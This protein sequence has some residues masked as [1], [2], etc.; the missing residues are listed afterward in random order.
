MDLINNSIEQ[1]SKGLY[2]DVDP[3]NQPPDTYRYA[4]NAVNESNEGDMSTISNE[5]SNNKYAFLKDNYVLIGSVYIGD[6]ETCIFSV[7]KDNNASEIG[8][9]SE[10]SSFKNE[11]TENNYKVWCNDSNSLSSEKLNFKVEKQ[12]QATFRLRRGCEKMVY[13]VDDY[14]V[15]RQVNLSN[16]ELYKNSTG[17]FDAQKFSIIKG[18]K[19]IPKCD[20]VEIIESQGNLQPGTVSVLLQYSDEEKNFTNFVL[21][22]PNII[23]YKDNHK[24]SF[25]AIDGSIN[26]EYNKEFSEGR[27]DKAI[28]LSFSNFDV[29][30][31]FYRLAF[32]HYGNNTLE[33]SEVYLSDI[34]ST[35]Q[36]TYTYSYSATLEKTDYNYIETFNRNNFIRSAKTIEQKDNRLVLGNIKGYDLDFS[37][38]Q[39]LASKINVDCIVKKSTINSVNDIHNTK[40]PLSKINGTGFI[41]GEVTSLGIVYVFEDGF[42]SPVMHIPGKNNKDSNDFVYNTDVPNDVVG[43][44]P[45]KHSSNDPK[46]F[47]NNTGNYKYY[48]RESCENFD[49]WGVDS[50]GDS[51][52]NTYVRHHRFPSRSD[53]NLP[54]FVEQQNESSVKQI[55]YTLSFGKLSDKIKE[56]SKECREPNKTNLYCNNPILISFN[57][58]KGNNEKEKIEAEF[59]TDI[60]AS[61]YDTKNWFDSDGTIGNVSDFTLKILVGVYEKKKDGTFEVKRNLDNLTETNGKLEITPNHEEKES[62]PDSDGNITVSVYYKSNYVVSNSIRNEFSFRELFDILLTKNTE[63]DSPLKPIET[64]ILGVSLSNI[65]LP[66]KELTGKNCIG[67]YVVKQERKLTDRTILDTGVVVP[68]WEAGDFKTA[69]FV[70]PVFSPEGYRVLSNYPNDTPSGIY[71]R[72]FSLIAPRHKFNDHT[73]DN[74]THIVEQGFYTTNNSMTHITGQAVQNVNDYKSDNVS[75]SYS[76]FE[77]HDGMTLKN[78]I[79]YQ[80]MKYVNKIRIHSFYLENKGKIDIF[81]LNTCEYGTVEGEPDMLY[82]MDFSNKKLIFKADRD[83][84]GLPEYNPAND[85]R[86]YPY[87]YIYNNHNSF[88]SDFQGAKYYK[89]NNNISTESTYNS[90][91]GDFQIGGLR[92]YSTLYLN[93]V[94]RIQRQKRSWWQAIAGVALAVIGLVAAIFSGGSSLVLVGSGLALLGATA[95]GIATIIK[96]DNFNKAMTEHWERGLKR[97]VM[98]YW[99][100]HVYIRDYAQPDGFEIIKYQD[101][102]IRW[103]T[104]I[105][106]DLVFETDIN[107]SLRI[108]PKSDRNNFLKPFTSHMKNIPSKVEYGKGWGATICLVDNTSSGGWWYWEDNGM[109]LKSETLEELFFLNKLCKQDGGRKSEKAYADNGWSYRG[110]PIPPIYFVN[111]DYQNQRKVLSHYMTPVEYSFCSECKETFPQRFVWSE[112]SQSETLTDNYKIFLPNNYKDITGEY[113]DITNIFTFN[114]QLYIHTKEGLFMQPTNYQERITNGIVSYI[115]TGEFGSLPAL[116]IL[117]DKYGNSAGLQ[118]REAQIITPYG[119]FFVSEREKKIYKFDGKLIPISDIGMSNWF[120][121]HIQL[122]L[123]KTYRINNGSEYPYNDNPSNFLGTGFILTYDQDKERIIVT[124]KDYIPNQILSNSKDYNLCVRD[125]S[126]TVFFE[127]SKNKA[128]MEGSD[129]DKK[130]EL[131]QSVSRIEDLKGN[132]VNITLTPEMDFTFKWIKNCEITYQVVVKERLFFKYTEK[133]YNVFFSGATVSTDN[134]MNNG[135]T[136]SFS[137]KNNTWASFHSYIPNAYVRMND[138]FFSWVYGN[139]NIYLHNNP[140]LFQNFYGKQH[141]YI[142]EYVSGNNPI[143][144]NIFNH[145]RFITEA[146]K[147]DNTKKEWYTKRWDTFNRAVFYN[148]RQCSGELV[149]RVKDT[150]E[151]QED[152]LK[153]QIINQ[154]NNSILIDR[155]EKDWLVNDVRDIRINYETPIWSEDIMDIFNKYQGDYMDKTLNEDS[156]DVNKDWFNLENFRDKFLVVRLIFDNFADENKNT[157]LVLFITNENNNISQY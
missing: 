105:L 148:T 49:Y 154:N 4:L 101:D 108:M 51:L 50:R 126:V 102:T 120:D 130:R 28:K 121:N 92:E 43:V 34:I 9:L 1:P 68:L 100:A 83:I 19:N 62:A 70:D 94:Q 156:L 84:P 48:Q 72:G 153:N 146:Y 22:V 5:G 139:K 60:P 52:V 114:N 65:E 110:I 58:S 119:Y 117:D 63:S 115:G 31:P 74:F 103:Y 10:K 8:I 112:V 152:Y 75:N 46:N 61:T 86:Q 39:K 66:S 157:K 113:G 6:G 73:F 25:S 127:I 79:R 44:F 88:Y 59:Y 147:F 3:V 18:F 85:E 37:N 149:L 47:K 16:K 29:N 24:Q 40:N 38:L 129:L 98:D 67:Y 57:V 33:V 27:T 141:P 77:D 116:P 136:I 109:T 128:I 12:I 118:Q 131:L 54:L 140:Y 111:N 36:T 155:N 150:T 122:E 123:N 87:V 132:P 30:Y 32:V 96:T 55:S 21:E 134:I 76:A 71:K 82:N 15:P 35:R 104:E 2:T 42:E 151:E 142:V 107:I 26:V 7:R 45:M 93:I 14:N 138:I 90:F 13:W 135:W 17:N 80:K 133:I 91:C 56:L 106:G 20:S 64:Y 125:D 145:L 78:I 23:I 137:L 69:S 144:T 99:G 124:K 143:V 41:P 89:L 97:T 81:N 95:Y 11:S 53:L